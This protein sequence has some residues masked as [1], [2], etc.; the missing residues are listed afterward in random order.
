MRRPFCSDSSGDEGS[1][2][3]VAVRGSERRPQG[4]RAVL[5]PFAG[6]ASC[7]GPRRAADR[8]PARTPS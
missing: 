5:A 3:S 1:L 6:A 8:D 4:G 7:S 2:L